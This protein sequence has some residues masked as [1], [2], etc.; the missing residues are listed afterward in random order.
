MEDQGPLTGHCYH[1]H[2]LSSG[3]KKE[4]T[5]L[6]E[7]NGGAVTYIFGKTVT[8]LLT[9]KEE[10]AANTY[11]IKQ[12]RHV[13]LQVV[14]ED[15]LHS[16]LAQAATSRPAR[17]VLAHISSSS[18]H[19]PIISTL[20]PAEGPTT[21][22]FKVAVFGLNFVPS[23]NFR[24]TFGSV[25][26]SDYEFHSSSSVIWYPAPALGALALICPTVPVLNGVDAGDVPVAASNDGGRTLGFPVPFR[27]FDAHSPA[28]YNSQEQKI[29]LLRGQLRNVSRA[30]AN[31][32]K[33]EIE[34]RKELKSITGVELLGQPEPD[35]RGGGGLRGSKQGLLEGP[36]RRAKK[37]DDE[38]E[39][40]IF[41]SSPFKDMQ[42]ERDAVVRTIIP[43]LRKICTER[44]VLITCIDLR[45][46]VQPRHG[47]TPSPVC[48]RTCRAFHTQVADSKS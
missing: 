34:L 8:H 5:A 19:A 41:L 36:A 20:L 45:W 3:K 11:K 44:D 7:D 33:M 18:A 10:L 38:R 27:F 25:T 17:V 32:Q 39:I 24:I 29:A 13:G 35:T 1:L 12:A 4:L 42:K 48:T 23:A 31:I 28:L 30:I 15:F 22:D 46:Y 43:K 40:R 14:E 9:T 2:G 6:I 21:G 26:A 47:V 16:L 37:S